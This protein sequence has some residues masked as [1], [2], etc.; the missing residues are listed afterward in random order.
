MLIFLEYLQNASDF[1]GHIH[2]K[3]P[4]IAKGQWDPALWGRTSVGHNALGQEV[5]GAR[6]WGV[7]GHWGKILG[8]A[9]TGADGLWGTVHWDRRS[10]GH[11]V[12]GH[13]VTGAKSLGQKVMGIGARRFGAGRRP[14]Y[15]VSNIALDT[16]CSNCRITIS[17]WCLFRV[18]IVVIVQKY[19]A[20]EQLCLYVVIVVT[21][22]FCRLTNCACCSDRRVSLPIT[23]VACACCR[24]CRQ[25][26]TVDYHT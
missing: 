24:N 8:A 11:D 1:P 10:V 20:Y 12:V 23:L 21:A 19:V 3:F 22:E 16:C 7:C 5:S 9:C 4:K 14:P 6:R 13:S 15:Q 17:I 25:Q 26:S 2:Q 18:L